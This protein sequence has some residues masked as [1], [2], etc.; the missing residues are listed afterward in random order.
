[1]VSEMSAPRQPLIVLIVK[2]NIGLN[3]LLQQGISERVYYS[4]LV[5]KFKGNVEK[6]SEYD[7]KI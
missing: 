7:Q 1:M 6:T 3:T 2:Y 5:C 4:D